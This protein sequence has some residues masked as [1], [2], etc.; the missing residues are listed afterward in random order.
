MGRHSIAF[1]L[2]CVTASGLDLLDHLSRSSLHRPAPVFDHYCGSNISTKGPIRNTCPP[3]EPGTSRRPRRHQRPSPEEDQ[4]Q[5]IL[6]F[7]RRTANK[8]SSSSYAPCAACKYLRRK[9]TQGCIFAPYF[10]PDNSQ[11]FINVHKVFGASN[12]GKILNELSPG[13]Q[14][15]EVVKSL[16]YEAECRIKDPIYGCV[17]LVSLLQHHLCQVHQE[18]D[19][20]RQELA[21]YIGSAAA[22]QPHNFNFNQ[23]AGQQLAV[24]QEPQLQMSAALA[25]AHEQQQQQMYVQQLQQQ[26][27]QQIYVQQLQQ[28]QQMYVQ[29]QHNDIVRFGDA[30]NPQAGAFGHIPAAIVATGVEAEIA[31]GGGGSIE[32]V[33]AEAEAEAVQTYEY[34]VR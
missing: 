7:R 5:K 27:Q 8:M 29:Q 26:Q 32:E 25:P 3:H 6:R 21:T 13:G 18:I 9:C 17:G 1:A 23:A 20:A 30:R 31:L 15:N 4:K 33:V 14:R 2:Y 11:K 22:M 28:Q 34:Q 10:P 24:I 16:A 19:W 12:V